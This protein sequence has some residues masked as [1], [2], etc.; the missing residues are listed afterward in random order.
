VRIL[1][2]YLGVVLI[3]GT[4]PL[5]ISVSNALGGFSFAAAGRM[6]VGLVCVGVLALVTRTRVPWHRLAV[7]SYVAAGTGI[8][9]AMSLAY[10]SA[11][12]IP[13]GWI[14]VVFGVSPLITSGMSAV[15]L[16]ER[17]N[18]PLKL[19]GMVLGVV[20]LAVIFASGAAMGPRT[21]VGVLAIVLASV[22]HSGSA[23]A[24]KRIGAP[25]EPIAQ[26]F[27][28]LAMAVPC[29]VALWFANGAPLPDAA[30]LAPVAALMYLG[31]VASTLGFT[32]YYFLLSVLPATR[33]AL[34]L[35]LTPTVGLAAGCLL[36]GEPF[37]L[38]I[39]AG[40]SLILAG[41]VLYEAEPFLAQR[42][43]RA[44]IRANAPRS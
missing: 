3:W 30:P 32:L 4:T 27:G 38:K 35:L 13:S 23:V 2:A 6:V 12:R 40:T 7:A 31:V 15:V 20:G 43:L 21:L 29:F 36:L 17:S 24:I 42:R 34:I 33:V 1:A 22:I 8:F 16:G 5:A 19:F 39:A 44:G 18:T 25:L 28:G 11:E 14:A 9:C 26:V 10:W 37:T 41:L